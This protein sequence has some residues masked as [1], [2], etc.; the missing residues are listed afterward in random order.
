MITNAELDILAKNAKKKL[1]GGVNNEE[2]ADDIYAEL[3]KEVGE[4][5]TTNK[6]V[7]TQNVTIKNQYDEGYIRGQNAS[8]MNVP[9]END[10]QTE[11]EILPY[12]EPLF[13]GGPTKTQL[14]S[15]KKQWQGYDIMLTEIQ[16][17]YFVFRTLNRF[18]YKQI[19]A[20]PNVD[21]LQREEIICETVTLFPQNYKWD[22]MAKDKA[23][24]PSTFSQII[25]EKS[26]FTNEYAIEVL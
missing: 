14:D 21:A 13:V 23:G 1:E 15:W 20:L 3:R 19:V 22:K 26:G 10:L 17:Q 9:T 4:E 2:V 12:D 6:D 25:M 24:I 18:E 11:H 16:D 8:I 5:E 7:S